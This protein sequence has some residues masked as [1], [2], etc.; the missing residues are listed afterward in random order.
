M[1]NVDRALVLGETQN[2]IE[3]IAPGLVPKA[4][5]DQH[6]ARYHW[7]SRWCAGAR[8]LDIAC[9]TGYG[10]EILRNAGARSVI[11]IDRST[12][13]LRF[14][15]TRYFLIASCADAHYL[16]LTAESFDVVVSLE[17]IEHLDDVPK[18]LLECFRVLKGDGFLLL[19]TPNAEK[20]DGTNPYHVHEMTI[21]EL[22]AVLQATG[23]VLTGI[24]GQQW[25]LRGRLFERV[26][27]FRRFAWEIYRHSGIVRST[28]LTMRAAT[29]QYWCIAAAKQAVA[30][31]KEFEQREALSRISRL[32]GSVGDC[33][34]GVP[35][36]K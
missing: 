8:V 16:P 3:R 31:G 28:A 25:T 12:A 32:A 15:Q 10:A 24:W 21:H 11:S 7:A 35:E 4:L 36:G 30:G 17:T 23:F 14:A 9:G 33:V 19:S 20:G 26:P 27:G 22:H 18:F 2:A 34:Y 29:P 13:A 5:E 6:I 1:R